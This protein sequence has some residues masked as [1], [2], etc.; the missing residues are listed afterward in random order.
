MIKIYIELLQPSHKKQYKKLQKGVRQQ[1][2]CKIS[3]SLN[4]IQ[5]ITELIKIPILLQIN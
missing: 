2:I 4:K 3:F 5:E 1:L